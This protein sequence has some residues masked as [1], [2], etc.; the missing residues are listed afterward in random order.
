MKKRKG[1]KLRSRCYR[2]TDGS[3]YTI[4]RHL[5]MHAE[6]NVEVSEKKYIKRRSR[7]W[8]NYGTRLIHRIQ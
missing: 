2:E 3:Q 1:S 5:E 4:P 6:S 7:S 8:R